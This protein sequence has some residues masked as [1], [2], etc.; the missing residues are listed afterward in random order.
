MKI[1]II[2]IPREG[3][4]WNL[5]QN[6]DPELDLALADLIH[7]SPYFVSINLRPLDQLGSFQISGYFKS[8]WDEPCS[9]CGD[10]FKFELNFHFQDILI[11]KIEAPSDEDIKHSHHININ[12]TEDDEFS[13]FEYENEIFNLGDYLHEQVALKIPLAPSPPITNQGK[14]ALCHK[15][16]EDILKQF[17]LLD[18]QQPVQKKSPFEALKKIKLGS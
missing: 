9:R 3:N 18:G 11:P 7:G 1:R 8:K 10:E 12:E 2:D 17:N 5:S 4:H 16:T 14:C 6:E 15:S 13:S